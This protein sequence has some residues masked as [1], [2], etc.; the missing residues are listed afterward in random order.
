MTLHENACDCRFCRGT[1]PPPAAPGVIR[2]S[3][4]GRHPTV[5]DLDPGEAWAWLSARQ[6]NDPLLPGEVLRLPASSHGCWKCRCNQRLV[7]LR[8]SGPGIATG[9]PIA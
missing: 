8:N 2:V 1:L 4:G 5:V 9:E 7:I 3:T 6:T